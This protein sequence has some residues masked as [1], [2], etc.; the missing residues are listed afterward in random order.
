MHACLFSPQAAVKAY[1]ELPHKLNKEIAELAALA[2]L[3]QAPPAAGGAVAASAGPG[4]AADMP[5]D[6]DGG[7][8]AAMDVDPPGSTVKPESDESVPAGPA[9]SGDSPAASAAGSQPAN[10]AVA[11][12][13][14]AAAEVDKKDAQEGAGEDNN[15][16]ICLDVPEVSCLKSLLRK[17]CGN[18]SCRRCC[19]LTSVC[20][21]FVISG[22]SR[23][24]VWPHVLFGLFQAAFGHVRQSKRSSLSPLSQAHQ[25]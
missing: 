21:D 24:K 9:V 13:L 14:K 7:G 22:A 10:A 5:A 2:A 6:E 4:G 18:G 8:S 19:V 16:P 1:K 15:C 17:Y 11:A 3:G 12:L 23:H 20:C 25:G